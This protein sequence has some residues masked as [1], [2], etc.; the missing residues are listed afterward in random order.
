M[1]DMKKN[2]LLNSDIV[3]RNVG[4]KYWA[5]NTKDGNQFKLNEVSFFILNVF[6]ERKSISAMLELV[7]KE[8][9]ID[10]ETLSADCDTIL[11]YAIEKEILKEV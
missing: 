7:M 8:Y 11:Q 10:I 3:L 4:D 9:K 5:L 2:I 6:R 1:L